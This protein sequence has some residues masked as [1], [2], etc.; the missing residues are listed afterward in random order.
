MKI[1]NKTNKFSVLIIVLVLILCVGAVS[2]LFAPRNN[3]NNNSSTEINFSNLTMA[4]LGD[5]IV[6]GPINHKSPITTPYCD[7]VKE[8]LGLRDVYNFGCSWSSIACK[9]SCV[10]HPDGDYATI[11]E[12]YVY[13]YMDLP[14][15]DIIHV[16]CGTNDYGLGVPIG[17]ID[18]YG[19]STYYGALNMMA[20]G[21]KSKYPN[22]YIFFMT[23][24]KYYDYDNVSTYGIAMS[25]YTNAVKNV[26]AKH[27]I[28]CFDFFNEVPIDKNTQTYDGIHPIQDYLT[29]TMAPAITQFIKD[30]Y[31]K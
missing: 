23:A 12:P 5:S 2:F 11:H 22:S 27:N 18:D 10:C 3:D 19:S 9:S 26:C 29:N 8:N 14:Q 28:D 31:K 6:M 24:C 15:A 13:R 16:R 25:E 7:I 4:C 1:N 30:N 17:T 21:L 20:S